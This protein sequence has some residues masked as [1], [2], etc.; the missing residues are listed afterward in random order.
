MRTV[1]SAHRQFGL[2]E[3]PPT[4]WILDRRRR[5]PR[6]GRCQFDN[7]VVALAGQLSNP[8]TPDAASVRDQPVAGE[9]KELGV[10]K[11]LHHVVE[12]L[13]HQG[14]EVAVADVPS[15]HDQ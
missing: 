10:A 1:Y 15:V 14:H 8:A 5:C 3:A 6:P 9:L 13:V 12:M 4:N 2:P 7:K 11:E